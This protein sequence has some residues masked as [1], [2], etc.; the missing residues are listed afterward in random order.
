MSIASANTS[1]NASPVKTT[2]SQGKK[3]L[4]K[5]KAAKLIDKG[6][7]RLLLL[8]HLLQQLLHPQFLYLT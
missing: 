4:G 2:V 1:K 7:K 6:K 3:P 5:G 8:P